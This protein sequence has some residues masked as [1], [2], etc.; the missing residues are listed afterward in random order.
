MTREQIIDLVLELGFD[1]VDENTFRHRY[2]GKE[3]EVSFQ[4]DKWKVEVFEREK[5]VGYYQGTME[6]LTLDHC[7]SKFVGM[8]FLTN[9]NY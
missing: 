9:A 3:T 1:S 7:C 5:L 6:P 8:G 2:K 4:G